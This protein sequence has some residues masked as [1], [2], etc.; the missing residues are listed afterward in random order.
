MTKVLFR[1]V[2]CLLFAFIVAQPAFSQ[3]TVLVQVYY[4]GYASECSWE[5]E[6][7]LDRSIVL[8]GGPGLVN[9]SFSY[10]GNVS[11]PAGEYVFK[12]YDTD[13]DGWSLPGGW[14]KIE[15]ASGI[16]TGQIYF[17]TGF[18]QETDFIVL[19]SS[20]IELGMVAWINPISSATLTSTEDVTVRMRN[21][22]QSSVSNF[23]LSYSIDGG[24]TYVTETYTGTLLSGDFVDYTFIQQANFAAAGTYTC[25]AI[26][27]AAGD[28]VLVNDTVHQD[29]ESIQSVS[30]FPWTESFS[31]W[32]PANWSFDGANTWS[33][34]LNSSAYCNFFYWQS[35]TADMVTPPINLYN[36]A[37]L[38]F[39][40][41]SG[42]SYQ[43]PND[44]FQ[45]LVSTDNG[46]TWQVIWQ[47]SGIEL[48]S[49]DGALDVS[50]GSFVQ[51]SIDLTPFE[52]NVAY[53]KFSGISG[54]GYNLYI[55]DVSV[56]MNP[57]S[58]ISILSW[59][60]PTQNDC[61]LTNSENVVL[62]IKNVGA[63]PLSNY[64][65]SYS[66]DGGTSF[67]S[68]TGTSL[69]NP[70]DEMDYTFSTTAD[71]SNLGLYS[72]EASVSV[73]GDF[74]LTNNQLANHDINH[75]GI[76][77]TFPYSEDFE[78]GNQDWALSSEKFGEVSLNQFN[79]NYA[80]KLEGGSAMVWDSNN[81]NKP[82]A[83][84]STGTS[85]TQAWDQNSLF[86]STA[87]SCL[88]DATQ[89]S[90]VEMLFDLKQFYRTGPAFTWLRVLVNGVAVSNDQGITDLHPQTSYN[91]PFTTH[92][93]DLSAYAGTQFVIT[94]QASNKFYSGQYAPGNVSYIDNIVIHEQDP[95]DVSVVSLLS[96]ES[97][98][99][100]TNSEAIE[101]Q[102]KNEGGGS[103]SN[104]D[105]S[106]SINGA[107]FITNTVTSVIESGNTLDYTFSQV[108]D[109]STQGQYNIAIA[110]SMSGDIDNTNDT[111][112]FVV[113]HSSPVAVSISGLNASYCLYDTPVTLIGNP[114]DGSFSGPGIS[115]TTF[116]P[117][118]AGLGTH[119]IV[120]SYTDTPTGC[121]S[122]TTQS[123]SVVG[124][125]VSFD[126]LYNGPSLVPV[127]V[128][129]YYNSFAPQ[130][131]S[132]E[133][134]NASGNV[135]LSSPSGTNTYGYDY[136]GTINLAFGDYTFIAHDT[137]GDGWN[138]SWFEITP[139]F[140]F[141]TGFTNYYVPLSQQPLTSKE[142][143]FSVGGTVE[144]CD[145]DPTVALTGTPAGGQFSGSGVVGASFNPAV[146]G[147]GVHAIT[148]TYNDGTCTGYETQYVIVESS[149]VVDLGPDQVLCEGDIVTLDAGSSGST[150]IWNTGA[151]TQTLVLTQSGQYNVT[152]SSSVGCET[153]GSVNITFNT[154]PIFNLGADQDACNGETV[155][156]EALATG[157]YLWNNGE[158]TSSINVT[159]YGNYSVTVTNQNCTYADNVTID[160]H[161]VSVDLGGDI[162]LCQGETQIVNAGS[163]SFYQYAWSNG[164]SSQTIEIGTTGNYGVT[165]TD[166][167]GCFDTDD[168][169]ITVNPLPIVDLGLDVTIGDTIII[170]DA[171]IGNTYYQ[172]STGSISM[173]LPIDGSQ[174]QEGDYTYWVEV[175]SANGCSSTDTIVVTKE[176]A[177]DIQS[178]A[179][180]AGWGIFSTYIDPFYPDMA[181][182]FSNIVTNV[183]I[184]KNGTGAV[185]WPAFNFNNI[186]D[187]VLGQGY[188]IF[189]AATDTLEVVG[190]QLEPELTPF[191]IP[192]GWS[193]IGYLRETPGNAE[194]M[195]SSIVSEIQLMKNGGG[196]VYWPA[197]SFN[198][199][200]N[201]L[202]GS[203]YQILLSSAQQFTYPSNG[204][205]AISIVPARKKLMFFETPNNTGHNMTLAIPQGL[206]SDLFSVG[207]EIAVVNVNGQ[208]L[209]AG[210]YQE[211]NVVLTIWGDDPHSETIEGI[212][213][214]QEFFVQKW[215]KQTSEITK[216]GIDY[217]IEGSSLY[218]YNSK[219]I[220]GSLSNS[221]SH[222]IQLTNYPNPFNST[223]TIVFTLVEDEKISLSLYSINGKFVEEICCGNYKNG[224]H[225]IEFDRSSLKSGI[226]Y[227]IL[228]TSGNRIVKKL[229]ID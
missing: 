29:I 159:T 181:D 34:Y 161:D 49:N 149:P 221:D 47:K 66:L 91:D 192:A 77:N 195:M 229:C 185:Y 196:Q 163:G 76:I 96:P 87:Q 227:Y 102:I 213:E 200:G 202:P 13:G 190:N 133:I 175:T 113:D 112:L 123:V 45:V 178:I 84:S 27:Q 23:S 155:V 26:V 50:P 30:S 132:W 129:V 211:G 40:W 218:H 11:L 78:T 118:L 15:P 22:G 126:G 53:L 173:T 201:M 100:L 160:F 168:L 166:Q 120:Y 44:E 5:I 93:Y 212:S 20:A 141:G 148:Y 7:K 51:E 104:F 21:F 183:N 17:P 180:P 24:T 10:N 95:P 63:A 41:S 203:G 142:V 107:P 52:N 94:F 33:S 25:F 210:I 86:H 98:C 60:Y 134:I 80:L 74:N 162:S 103:V 3:E 187:I 127:L 156:L 222:S 205:K 130:Q 136:N 71:F 59:E 16:S 90:T 82:W 37:T 165:V 147:S 108:A 193:I 225:F 125:E 139:D 81:I 226:Y 216:L 188:Q 151:S 117:N 119:N 228:E 70:G 128:Q 8:S 199:I 152:V 36:P 1:F 109:L 62:K 2:S 145:S 219:T 65:V 150:Y 58:D 48:F 92:R 28:P 171:G 83:G 111:L 214:G 186:Y 85:S 217:C 167:Y 42:Y 207:D 124:T 55:D 79:S 170:L 69:L 12:A 215:N 9:N 140:G 56:S 72:C 97:D 54:Y 144:M 88:I 169:N 157:T 172:W 194:L 121:V 35:G 6:N 46:N 135:V 223:T 31:V 198:G 153:I 106:Y 73:S 4:G 174:L 115:G 75:I 206:A 176:N 32:P 18:S 99:G 154:L 57:I 137:N 209:G 143:T 105:I 61:G 179:L 116:D 191:T 224:T 220:V 164:M 67:V 14:Y 184:V 38:S 197:F 204:A 64:S 110:V 39:S 158:T 122:S 208:V 138:S 114:V 43:V 89:L 182:I 189:M 19:S 101:V 177:E 131:Q 68:E 146:A